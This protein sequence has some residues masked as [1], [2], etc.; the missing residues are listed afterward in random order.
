M[1]NENKHI[2]LI[3]RVLTK[4]ADES[5]IS[6]F[7]NWVEEDISNREIFNSYKKTWEIS[8]KVENKKIL[9]VDVDDEWNRF[10]S[11]ISANNNQIE[12]KQSKNKFTV[13]RIAAAILAF[14]LI[15]TGV[16][17]VF[18]TENKTITA[19][20]DIQ[21][22]ELPDGSRITLNRESTITYSDTF[23]KKERNVK[24]KNGEAY[25]KVAKNNI[26]PFTVE[27]NSIFIKVTGTEFNVS[28]NFGNT[29]VIVTEGEVRVSKSNDKSK[30][31]RLGVG[32]KANYIKDKNTIVVSRN[33]DIN[34]ISWKTK[35]FHF[36]KSPFPDIISKIEKAYGVEI[37]THCPS[38]L[39]DTLTVSFENQTLTAVLNVL[40]LTSDLTIEKKGE[41]INIS[42][43]NCR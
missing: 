6:S 14:F 4:E 18:K 26:I 31:I 13:Y 37:E 11:K 35:V 8:G 34:Y 9:E 39:K 41:V 25:F 22:S 21:E 28:N 30:S 10:N 42:R 27:T 29:E 7:D 20:S 23:N 38:L 43:K 33:K 40:K 17:Y 16:L 1:E 12:I 5:E 32:D 24:L 3:F 19:Q 15:S 2:D 36:V